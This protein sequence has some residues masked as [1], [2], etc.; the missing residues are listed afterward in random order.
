ML[1]V[2]KTAIELKKIFCSTKAS[3][4]TKPASMPYL[5]FDSANSDILFASPNIISSANVFLC[6]ML[7]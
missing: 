3:S 4:L 6:I 7:K 1:L 2:M 5:V